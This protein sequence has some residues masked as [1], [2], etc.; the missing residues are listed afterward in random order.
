MVASIPHIHTGLF[1][2]VTYLSMFEN[3]NLDTFTNDFLALF[4]TPRLSTK[5]LFL[6]LDIYTTNCTN[7]VT[8][9]VLPHIFFS[10]KHYRN[11]RSLIC[12]VL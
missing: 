12:I 10:A 1:M 9:H 8:Q 11:R 7:G 2:T 5:V 4:L 3:V 6:W